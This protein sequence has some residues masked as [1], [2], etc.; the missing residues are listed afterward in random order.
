M[1]AQRTRKDNTTSI[2]KY[3]EFKRHFQAAASGQADFAP[4]YIVC[5]DDDYLKDEVLA[6]FRSVIDSEYA[7]FNFTRTTGVDVDAAIDSAYTFPMFDTRKVVILTLENALDESGKTAVEKY[8]SDPCD[9]TIFIIDCDDEIAKSLKIKKAQTVSCSRLDDAE[10]LS[11][12]NDLCQRPPQKRIDRD[13][14]LE[15][16][17]R[18]QGSMGRI[19][20]ELEKLKSYSEGAITK[21]D[22]CEM[23]SADIDFQIYELAN[24]VSEKNAAKAL[25]VLDVFFKNGIRG[26]TIINRLYDKYRNMLHAELNK[27]LSN[28]DL[29]KLLGMK[30]GAVY[31]LRKVSSN[32]SQ[33]RL[34][35]C[36]DYL[37][38]LQFDVLTGKR[39]D[40]SAIHEAILQ[41]LVI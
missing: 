38:S 26:V 20:V 3:G 30:S 17:S 10:I 27:G 1:Q 34:K 12:I 13:A 21:I 16:I 7:D 22:V 40:V 37:H 5:G 19:A 29:A 9:T 4:V 39:G 32:Y 35:K 24:A 14:A 2:M 31:F 41:L 15:L 8:V 36:V 11:E 28:D 25:E 18:T 6:L 33:M 23:V